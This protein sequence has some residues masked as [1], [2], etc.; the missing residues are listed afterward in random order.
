MADLGS[1][2]SVFI[3]YDAEDHTET[4][5]FIDLFAK[6]KGIL[7]LEDRR[8]SPADEFISNPSRPYILKQVRT[9]CLKISSVTIVLIGKCTHS[10]RFIDWEIAASL[11]RFRGA[12]SGLIGLVLNRARGSAL[13]PPRLGANWA[14][15]NVNCYARVYK[16]PSVQHELREMIEDAHA[17][18]EQRAHLISNDARLMKQNRKCA[19]CGTVHG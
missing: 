12:P 6:K 15:G 4:E 11:T 5:F 17:A 2:R 9:D 19:E 18:R 10:R 13:L 7:K 14:P 8:V 3:T 16:V 1:K